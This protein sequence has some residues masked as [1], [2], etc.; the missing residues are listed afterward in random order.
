MTTSENK[1][2][3][4]ELNRSVTEIA[5]INTSPVAPLGLVLIAL[6]KPQD[7]TAP[8]QAGSQ[9]GDSGSNEKDST[10]KEKEKEKEKEQQASS[11]ENKDAKPKKNYCN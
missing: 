6:V 9:S 4:Q 1:V 3:A 5:L 10:G 7:D 8:A 11:G 2:L